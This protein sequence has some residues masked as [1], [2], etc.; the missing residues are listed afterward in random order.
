[1]DTILN[2]SVWNDDASNSIDQTAVE[3]MRALQLIEIPTEGQL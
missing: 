3:Q 2:S 1:M